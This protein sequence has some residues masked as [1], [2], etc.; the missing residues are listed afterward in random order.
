MIKEESLKHQEIKKTKIGKSMGSKIDF[1][2]SE[3]F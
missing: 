1:L 2:S 3:V